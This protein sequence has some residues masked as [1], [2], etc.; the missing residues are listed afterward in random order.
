MK[1]FGWDEPNGFTSSFEHWEFIR[2][3]PA[4]PM[5]RR[6]LNFMCDFRIPLTFSIDDCRTVATVI[7]QVADDIF[8]NDIP[9]K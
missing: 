3:I 8:N 4:L 1:W 9:Q 2:D 6:I 5:T 7:Q